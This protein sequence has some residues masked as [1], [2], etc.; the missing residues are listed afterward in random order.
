MEFNV[1]NYLSNLSY[2]NKDFPSLW[3]EILETVPKL[4]NKWIPSEANESDPLVVLLKELAIIADKQNYNIDK[5]ILELFPA[6]LT[7]LRS[8]YNVY[9]S[10]GYTPDW[11]VSATTG[12][13]ITY[14]SY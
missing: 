1:E 6:T 2:I 3:N 5:N 8:A 12:I 11:Y 14:R 10:L 13:T 9:E 4:T 7:Q